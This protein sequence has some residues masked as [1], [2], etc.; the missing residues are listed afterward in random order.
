MTGYANL[1]AL[2]TCDGIVSLWDLSRDTK[3]GECTLINACTLINSC[4]LVII[5]YSF[6]VSAWMPQRFVHCLLPV[7]MSLLLVVF[8]HLT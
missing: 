7:I 8:V 5:V 6:I 4:H 3:V 2:G 1:L